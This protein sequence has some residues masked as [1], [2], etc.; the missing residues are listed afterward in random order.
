MKFVD[1]VT[2]TVQSGKGGAGAIS[3]RREKYVPRGGPDGGDGGD[4]GDVVLEASRDLWSLLDFTFRPRYTAENG[5]HGQG[6]RKHGRDG[7]DLV[8][9]VPVGTIVRDLHGKPLADLVE[10]GQRFVVARGGKGGRGNDHFKSPTCQAP[11]M[12]EPGAPGEEKVIT[13][14][15]RLL[16]EVGIIGLP[17]VGKSTLISQVSSA[18]PKIAAYPFTTLVPNLG[19]VPMD[20]RPVVWA[21]T[22]GLIAGAHRG[23]GLGTRFL[24]HIER[25]RVFLHVVDGALGDAWEGFQA[26][27]QELTAYNPQ[28][29]ERPLVVAVNKMDLPET[30][31]HWPALKKR[32]ARHWPVVPI[33]A[34]TGQGLDLLK[35]VL[36]QFLV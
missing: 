36:S 11:R 6:A 4:G 21:D 31:K 35:Q 34:V 28:L 23:V 15:L 17:N 19:V 25:T 30:K 18:R 13:L 12:A 20:G 9:K 26:V 5:G 3:F 29:A 14:D 1:E 16:A 24:K 7:Q 10:D 2:I 33:S 27:Q 22:P 8:L 32:F